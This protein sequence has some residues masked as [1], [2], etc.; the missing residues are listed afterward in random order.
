ML[1]GQTF[2]QDG[3]WGTQTQNNTQLI[4]ELI[5]NDNYCISTYGTPN[6]SDFG[7]SV[8]A[9]PH[10]SRRMVDLRTSKHY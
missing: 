4:D 5:D 8:C 6:I 3:L 2:A 9:T 1:G 10:H 7:F